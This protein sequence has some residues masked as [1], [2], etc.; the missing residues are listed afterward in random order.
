MMD[1]VL[2]DDA[3]PIVVPV[4]KDA[5]PEQ[6]DQVFEGVRALVERLRLATAQAENPSMIGEGPH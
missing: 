5:A 1:K 4:R 2:D 3:F 6:I